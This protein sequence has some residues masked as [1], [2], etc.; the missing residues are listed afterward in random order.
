MT[1]KPT[2]EM[3]DEEVLALLAEAKAARQK[4]IDEA[5]VNLAKYGSPLA[6][7]VAASPVRRI[8][9]RAKSK[10]D[11]IWFGVTKHCPHCGKDK[12]VGQDF[13]VIHAKDGTQKPNGWCK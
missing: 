11:A 4:E 7:A 1:K 9:P 5:R 2:D 10:I 6:P 3:T 13:G 8:G 12:N